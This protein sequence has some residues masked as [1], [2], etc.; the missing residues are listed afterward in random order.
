MTKKLKF[1]KSFSKGDR[2]VVAHALYKGTFVHVFTIKMFE[3]LYE[4]IP[5]FWRVAFLHLKTQ[6]LKSFD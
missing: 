5:N 1:L 3:D 4:E 6:M 2:T